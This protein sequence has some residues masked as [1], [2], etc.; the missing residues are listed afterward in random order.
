MKIKKY[1]VSGIA[2]LLTNILIITNLFAEESDANLNLAFNPQVMSLSKKKESAFDSPSATYVLSSEDIR[3]SGVTSIPEAL[4]LVPGVQVA[5]LNGHSY[6]ITVRGFERQFSNKLLVMIDGRTIYTT[7]FSGVFWD[8]QDYVLEDID[9]IEVIRGPGGTIW[10]ANAV[11]GVIN[12]ITKNSSQTKGFYASQTLG[13]NDRTITEF[14][15]GGENKSKDSYR[16]YAKT[17]YRKG[18]DQ[19]GSGLKNNDSNLNNRTGFRYDISSIKNHNISIKGDLYN[20]VAK[21]YF[22]KL[23]DPNI[24]DKSSLG[25]NVIFGWDNKIS[26][27]SKTSFNSYLDYQDLELPFFRRVSKTL[28]VDFQ[29]F[30]SITSNNQVTWGLGYRQMQDEI[31]SSP[32]FI[33]SSSLISYNPSWRN[34]QLFSGF[35]QDKISIDNFAIIIGSKFEKNDFTGFEYQPNAKFVYYPARNQ[36]L[37]SSI[38]RAVRTP[39]RG[40]DDIKIKTSNIDVYQGKDTY[41]A[42]NMIAYEAG[43]RI[44][45]T[46][47][48]MIDISTFYNKYSKLRTWEGPKN[49]TAIVDNLGSGDSHGFEITGKWQVNNKLLLEAS[50]DYLKLNTRISSGSTDATSIVSST[51]SLKISEGQSPRNQFRFRSFYNL[52]SNIE[53]DNMIY[54]VDALPT[55]SG[56]PINQK[57]IPSYLRI[58]ARLGYQPTKSWDLSIGIQ[59][60][61]DHRHREFK[62]SMFNRQT[63]IGRMFYVKAVWQY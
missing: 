54:F 1:F 50:Y 17:N 48:S 38:S 9:R 28:D 37:W 44:K 49:S 61:L 25:A 23:T 55:G 14:R 31:K 24:T 45:P 15:Y 19:Y 51:D 40:E 39:T 16:L 7:L 20:S 56:N 29:N 13:D 11:N 59:N 21:N 42:E 60:I 58:D 30:L 33:S 36:T 34:D 8:E 3:R 6:A 26:K 2:L 63:E 47:Q 46:Y 62:P 35:L 32:D 10:G 27:K 18:L 53:L 43:Y 4:R 52:T 41:K 57:G 12:I 22:A 5:R